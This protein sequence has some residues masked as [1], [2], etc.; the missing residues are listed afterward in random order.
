MVLDNQ[1]AGRGTGKQET[2]NHAPGWG[3][4]RAVGCRME[5]IRGTGESCRLLGGSVGRKTSGARPLGRQ[6]LA[7]CAGTDHT[8][9]RRKQGNG[10]GAEV[11]K[12]GYTSP[13]GQRRR[14]WRKAQG[15]ERGAPRGF[16]PQP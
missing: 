15:E 8:G 14:S 2:R 1:S 13:R 3:A 4:S 9:E 12:R 11:G 6:K 5:A 16:A 10:E 7:R